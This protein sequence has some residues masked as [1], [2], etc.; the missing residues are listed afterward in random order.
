[1][2]LSIPKAFRS[3]S[4]VG[5]RVRGRLY[6]EDDVVPVGGDHHLVLLAAWI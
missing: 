1:M 5:Y 4:A 3:V 2:N 6:D